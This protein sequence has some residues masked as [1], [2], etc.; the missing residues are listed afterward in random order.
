MNKGLGRRWARIFCYFL[1]HEHNTNPL[2]FWCPRCGLAYEEFCGGA[3]M[4]E[5]MIEWFAEYREE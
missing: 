2:L 3:K 4:W 1:G 5:D